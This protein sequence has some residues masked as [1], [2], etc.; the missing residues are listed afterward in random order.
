MGT[1]CFGLIHG[2]LHGANALSRKV[3]VAAVGFDD[4][5]CGYYLH[6][7]AVML[8]SLEFRPNFRELR[9]AF[10]SGYCAVCPLLAEH[11]AQLNLFMAAHWVTVG[12]TVAREPGNEAA[13]ED[14]IDRC[15]AKLR[16]FLQAPESY[17]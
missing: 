15:V 12:L 4:C 8:C 16:Q 11:V 9:R 13:R 5:C 14:T 10:L 17:G 2:A 3:D 6:D 1:G 7:I